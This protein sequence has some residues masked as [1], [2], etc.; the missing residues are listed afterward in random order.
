MIVD[1]FLTSYNELRDFADQADFKS[2]VNPI[3]NV[4]YPGI[5]KDIP[6]NIK[7]E[8]LG[9][10]SELKGSNLLRAEMFLRMSPKGAPC[11]HQ[12]HTDVI[13]GDFSCMLY[14][15]RQEHCMGG[16][17]IL[18]HK[19]T[20]IG[21]APESPDFIKIISD[22]QNNPSAWDVVDYAVMHPNRAFIFKANRVHRAEPIGGF[23]ATSKDARIVLTCFFS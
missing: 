7:L 20:G 5:C 22:D 14:L 23:G 3:D 21:Y 16:T 12:A 18:R 4:S 17:S 10:L 8:I 13:M 11:P 2:A 19:A 6:E 9:K 15:N 1:S